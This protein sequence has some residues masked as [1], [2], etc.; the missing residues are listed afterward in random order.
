MRAAALLGLL[1]SALFGCVSSGAGYD[2]T[3]STLRDRAQLELP[4]DDERDQVRADLLS[5]PLTAESAARLA[6]AASPD[7][8]AALAGVGVSRAELVRALRLPNPKGEIGARFGHGDEPVLEI[9]ATLDLIDLVMLPAREAGASLRLDAA[10]L[11]AAGALVDVAHGAKIAFYEAQAAAQV[12]ELERTITFAAAQSSDFASRLRG[13]GNVPEL[14]A[15]LE[16]A[17]FEEARLSLARAEVADA[18]ARERLNAALGLHGAAASSWKLSGRLAEPDTF[19]ATSLEA[20]AVGQNLDLAALEKR[21]GAAR[22]DVDLA[23][24]R[25]LLPEIEAGVQL[26]RE[27]GEWAIGPVVGVELPLFYQGQGEV[28]AA[29]AQMRAAKGAHTGVAV[30]VRAAAR[31]I[32][33]ELTGTRQTAAF[34]KETLLPLRESIVDATLRKYNAMDTG[35]AEVLRAKRDQIQAARAY[36][37]VLREYWITRTQADMLLAGRLPFALPSARARSAPSSEAP[38]GGH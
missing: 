20:K 17:L 21:Y 12:L 18:A 3:R 38:G 29:E 34:Y 28:A 26:E 5:R 11:E 2:L 36:V 14:D 23:W 30:K 25:G 8:D 13:A 15:L 6:L 35:P 37:E 27:G 32:A 9:A 10:A 7:V 24:A 19:D 16:R 4:A 33:I 22:S 1:A 31:S